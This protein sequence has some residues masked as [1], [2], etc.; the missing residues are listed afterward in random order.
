MWF[1][2]RKSNRFWEQFFSIHDDIMMER[3]GEMKEV[4]FRSGAHQFSTTR[5]I[6]H[7][8]CPQIVTFSA[9]LDN[10]DSIEYNFH[11]TA[12]GCILNAI[13]PYSSYLNLPSW[14]KPIVAYGN[15]QHKNVEFDL[16]LRVFTL[17]ARKFQCATKQQGRIS[18]SQ[19]P[20]MHLN[21]R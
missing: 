19:M 8:T 10:L 18:M 17:H 21:K 3:W 11:T 7:I 2:W 6:Y 14:I 9:R 5:L 4:I 15:G 16:L 1:F 20:A 12:F 13:F